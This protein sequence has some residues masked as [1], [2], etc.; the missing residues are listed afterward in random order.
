MIHIVLFRTCNPAGGPGAVQVVGAFSTVEKAIGKLDSLE[1]WLRKSEWLAVT[2]TSPTAVTFASSGATTI[3]PGCYSI[4][5][6]VDL[7]AA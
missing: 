3:V 4:E 6:G 7:D 1:S 2:R 5:P